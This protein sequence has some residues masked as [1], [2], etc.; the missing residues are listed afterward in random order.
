MPVAGDPLAARRRLAPDAADPQVIVPRGI[1]RPVA[2]DPL[3]VLARRLLVRRHLLDRVRRPLGTTA[4][5]WGHEPPVRQTPHAPAPGSRPV[6]P[7]GSPSSAT[8]VGSGAWL[9]TL[10]RQGLHHPNGPGRQERENDP[11]ART[12]WP[13][14][15]KYRHVCPPWT[16]PP[17][18]GHGSPRENGGEQP[19]GTGL[20]TPPTAGPQV[21]RFAAR[22]GFYLR[23]E[24]PSAGVRP[25]PPAMAAR[26]KM[27]NLGGL[28]KTG[29]P[30]LCRDTT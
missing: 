23:S 16:R 8:G 26:Q 7:D 30:A 5:P 28:P 11:A 22:S 9:L 10:R 14:D 17:Q 25:G 18:N 20:L 12:G 29:G 6:R 3:D 24:N 15:S 4:P 27:A 21:S 2:R 1:P 19:F 13:G